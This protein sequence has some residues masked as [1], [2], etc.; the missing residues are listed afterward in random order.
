MLGVD[1]M[2]TT[3][4]SLRRP[5]LHLRPAKWCEPCQLRLPT[6]N[7]RDAHKSWTRTVMPIPEQ[8]A[9]SHP[10]WPDAISNRTRLFRRWKSQW[11][12]DSTRSSLAER[13]RC[14]RIHSSSPTRAGTV[15]WRAGLRT[16][17]VVTW[18][19]PLSSSRCPPPRSLARLQWASEGL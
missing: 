15:L 11:C 4:A 3:R 1:L 19:V 17:T 12:A 10:T 9:S 8:C 6:I 7:L 5:F 16:S 14:S 2:R 18:C 13:E